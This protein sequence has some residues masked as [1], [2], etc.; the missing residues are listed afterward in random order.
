MELKGLFLDSANQIFMLPCQINIS[1]KSQINQT[2][3][4]ESEKSQTSQIESV[5]FQTNTTKPDE[6]KGIFEQKLTETVVPQKEFK[7]VSNEDAEKK[8]P[9]SGNGMDPY[10][11]TV[12]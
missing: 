7:K 12:A 2:R 10:R 8:R 9:S 1:E 5:K 3:P 4:T 11:E 6:L